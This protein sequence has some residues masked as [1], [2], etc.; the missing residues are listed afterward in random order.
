MG[1]RALPGKRSGT[2]AFPSICTVTRLFGR[3]R[4]GAVRVSVYLILRTQVCMHDR[5]AV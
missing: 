2:A 5:A 3:K 4:G 1:T